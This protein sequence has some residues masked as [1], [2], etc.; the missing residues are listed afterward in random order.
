MVIT[1][2]AL[3]CIL[4]LV[5]FFTLALGSTSPI[6]VGSY[7]EPKHHHHGPAADPHDNSK[8]KI[9]HNDHP[10]LP[11]PPPPPPQHSPTVDTKQKEEQQALN[12]MCNTYF[13]SLYEQ[14][15][16]W[17]IDP[18]NS[19]FPSGLDRRLTR[20]SVRHLRQYFNCFLRNDVETNR[21]MT[22]LE[23]RLYPIFK[24]N[25]PSFKRF[26]GR[27][28]SGRFINE[29]DFGDNG[30]VE[31]AD[32]HND[33]IF[34]ENRSK[35]NTADYSFFTDLRN[36]SNSRGIVISVG[37]GRGVLETAN[38]LE[39]L[40]M[41]G[42]KLPIEIVHKGDLGEESMN[43]LIRAAREPFAMPKSEYLEE[44]FYE[45]ESESESE[46]E[47]QAENNIKI[48]FDELSGLTEN[49]Q[50]LWFV[51]TRPC[52]A[53][54]SSFFQFDN[55][56]LALMFNSFDEMLMMDSDSVPFI[57][58]ADFFELEEYKKYQAYFFQDRAIN[59]ERVSNDEMSFKESLLPSEEEAYLY[60]M[61]KPNEVLKTPYF[62]GYNYAHYM[63]SGLFLV[64]RK[65]H[66]PELMMGISLN[67][68][69][70]AHMSFYGD[71]EF[72]WYGF[73]VSGSEEYV[74]NE[75]PAGSVGMKENGTGY[76]PDGTP[77]NYTVSSGTQPAHVNKNRQLLWV[78][79]GMQTCKVADRYLSDWYNYEQLRNKFD[80]PEDYHSHLEAP[81]KANGV[82][83]TNFIP[84]YE[85]EGADV[86][87]IGFMQCKER[88]CD[89]Y[90]WCAYD[91]PDHPSEWVEFDDTMKN[92]FDNV[93]RYWMG[94]AIYFTTEEQIDHFKE[95]LSKQ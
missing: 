20:Q 94:K 73:S 93:S 35:Q 51:N 87:E 3:V 7:F 37:E 11:P 9:E 70:D 2:A 8:D 36:Q 42:N 56:W 74:V 77:F 29:K 21:N 34:T 75:I 68:L 10:S 22:E 17:Q 65:R 61:D 27:E 67:Y 4:L 54:E 14:S 32:S 63:E 60:K 44:Y 6:R 33:T 24:H 55:K 38:L 84:P 13:D 64:S 81:I 47:A 15:P 19:D 62:G 90:T 49:P 72:F 83:L 95:H 52:I 80:S 25:F 41:Q 5:D 48:D 23:E 39:V 31:G 59:A 28:V 58:L 26:D 57:N 85:F 78:N 45:T 43:L 82:M 46:N 30:I 1:C 92:T 12:H 86:Q 66:L 79:S 50:E 69:Q 76:K 53:S 16:N 40:R 18:A 71:K 91:T 89:G 88:G